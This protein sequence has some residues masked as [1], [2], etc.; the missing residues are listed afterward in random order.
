MN[1]VRE[2]RVYHIPESN[3]VDP[4]DVFIVW[5]GE[6]RSQ[7]TI[8][9]W[10]RA[11]TAYRGGHLTEKVECYLVECVD[12]GMTDH[13]ANLFSR[14]RSCAEIAWLKR[15]MVNISEYLKIHLGYNP[16]DK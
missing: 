14:T 6:C 11:W 1:D 2:V 8:R 9:C 7:I 10:D 4:I 3:N 16:K 13:L 15:I 5:Y 12:R